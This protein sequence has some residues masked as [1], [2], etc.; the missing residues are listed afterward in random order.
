MGLGVSSTANGSFPGLAAFGFASVSTVSNN[1]K[2]HEAVGGVLVPV[3][4]AYAPEP[5]PPNGTK[6]PARVDGLAPI[7]GISVIYA[8]AVW[9]DRVPFAQQVIFATAGTIR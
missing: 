3:V 9:A 1:K 5:L 7:V 8:A 4:Y 6:G 2:A